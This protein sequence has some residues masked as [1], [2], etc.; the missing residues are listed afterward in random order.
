MKNYVTVLG[1][2]LSLS[3]LT[4]QAAALASNDLGD[5]SYERETG[6]TQLIEVDGFWSSDSDSE[7]T[8]G[9]H[10]TDPEDETWVLHGKYLRNQVTATTSW[11]YRTMGVVGYGCTGTLVGPKHVLTAAHCVWNS[12]DDDWYDNLNF[13][14]GQNGKKSPYGKIKWARVV[15]PQAYVDSQ[16]SAY[17]FAMII[18]AEPIGDRV[19]WMSFGYNDWMWNIKINMNGYPEDKKYET[20]WHVFCPVTWMTGQQM[21]YQCDTIGG[22]SGSAV[23]RYL[24][25]ERIIYGVHTTGGPWFVNS[26]VRINKS[27]FERIKGW[28]AKYQ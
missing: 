17:D 11:P 26:G 8:Q 4:F 3:F 16:E 28:K 19:G 22:M 6:K 18:L 25:D 12:E 24:E 15:A 7:K 27:V 5:I 10:G 13:K 1:I 9:F 21:Y 14:P 2:G 20:L 23:Y